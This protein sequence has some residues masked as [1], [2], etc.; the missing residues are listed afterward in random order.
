MSK[1]EKRPTTSVIPWSDVSSA[2]GSRELGFR[3]SGITVPSGPE[4]NQEIHERRKKRLTHPHGPDARSRNQRLSTPLI[5]RVPVR[6]T[7]C[8][9]V[10][11]RITFLT[12]FR[13]GTR[14]HYVRE[15]VSSKMSI[16]DRQP[17]RLTNGAVEKA[18]DR[19]I[20]RHVL[21]STG[22]DVE[23]PL[24]SESGSLR[25]A[26]VCDFSSCAFRS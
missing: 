16:T 3:V 19:D 26:D 7:I 17:R 10:V 1:V 25:V 13:T 14:R 22:P 21:A 9:L 24:G 11:R 5:L 2:P 12:A 18:G 6:A 20:C 15:K 23:G 4:T 8:H